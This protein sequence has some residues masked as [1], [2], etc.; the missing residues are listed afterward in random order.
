MTLVV[1]L[2]TLVVYGVYYSMNAQIGTLQATKLDYERTIDSLTGSNGKLSDAKEALEK[3][4]NDV[5]QR[6]KE[7]N[8]ALAKAEGE[9]QSANSDNA[10]LKKSLTEYISKS[11]KFEKSNTYLS[12]QLTIYRAALD[13]PLKQ[14]YSAVME[15][16]KPLFKTF[17]I[18]SKQSVA[19]EGWDIKAVYSIERT[20][21]RDKRLSTE[22]LTF[23]PTEYTL[24]T[25]IRCLNAD[26]LC[27]DL[28]DL[29]EQ[30]VLLYRQRTTDED[31]KAAYDK[32]I[33][34]H[35]PDGYYWDEDS[36]T[37]AELAELARIMG[38]ISED[39]HLFFVAQQ[40]GRHN[41]GTDH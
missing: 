30:G 1:G 33:M 21:D 26:A 18:R 7:I 9:L 3:Y 8:G 40:M 13:A 39:S 12:Q 38:E 20:T 11:E 14:D 16:I 4:N 37:I 41:H 15:R 24:P 6:N 28:C 29:I 31:Y 5:E 17:T 10:S 23:A 22:L 19:I 34:K 27:D 25:S 35:K 2:A 32:F 36:M